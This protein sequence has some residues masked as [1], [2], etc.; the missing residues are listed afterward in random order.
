MRRRADLLLVERGFF[1][2]RARAQ[3]AIAAGLVIADGQPVRKASE[4]VLDTAVIQA[5]APHPYVS[6][7]GLKLA[8]GLDHFGLSPAGLHCLD[9]G[10]S[11]GGFTDVLLR[12][13]AACVTAID[14]GR[15][16]LHATI[17]ADPRVISFESTD[18]RRFDAAL[19][20]RPPT[21]AV[22]DVSFISLTLVLPAVTAL[23]APSAALVALIKPQFEVGKARV[24][25]GGIVRNE[26]AIEEVCMAIRALLVN[27]GWQVAGLI[28]SPVTGGD[29]NREYLVG[30]RFSQAQA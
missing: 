1:D 29:G 16:Q 20:L 28:N 9:V 30:A 26:A 4:Q 6:R 8:A 2:S 21:L 15:D 3:G 19:L 25:R 27:L 17:Q 5:R 12:R 22:I 23:V 13:G 24:E 14:T 7:G 10:S 11:T 18:V